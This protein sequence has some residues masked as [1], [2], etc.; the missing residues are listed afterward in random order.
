MRILHVATLIVGLFSSS[1]VLADEPLI[2]P[3]FGRN[4][5][6]GFAIPVTTEFSAATENLAASGTAL[7]TTPSP[8]ALNSMRESFADV[9]TTWGELS[10]LRF[11][12]LTSENRYERL[13]FWPDPRGVILRQV[14]EVLAEQESTAT[15]ADT[16]A[17]KSIAVQGMPALEYLLWGS[18]AEQLATGDDAF[19]CNYAAA[20][21]ENLHGLAVEI[22][23]R[24]REGSD[25]HAAFTEPGPDRELYRDNREVA[26]EF[27]KAL[28]T[29]L[30]FTMNAELGPAAGESLETAAPR[31]APLW[32]SD[33]TFQLLAAHLNGLDRLVAAT[34]LEDTLGLNAATVVSTLRF[35]LQSARDA[36]L[37]IETPVEAAFYDAAG[38]EKLRYAGLTIGY[39]NTTVHD[40]LT[41]AIGL[42]MGFN[43]LDG[44]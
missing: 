9:V 26:N 44:D 40:M 36:L 30:Q 35:D 39:A 19:R 5:A 28:A 16:L 41:G 29:T 13:F 1:P 11:G 20:A 43:A 7:C 33:L 25:F 32:R 37:S 14:Q 27:V 4:I 38:W 21:A 31:R 10:V 17:E 15:S 2:G 22:E 12:P 23:D 34:Q 6:D 42:V 18:G 3:D 8:Q 24:W